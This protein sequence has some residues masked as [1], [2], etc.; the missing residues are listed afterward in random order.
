MG[1]VGKRRRK[2][3][4]DRASRPDFIIAAPASSPLRFA[5]AVSA[6]FTYTARDGPGQ[7]SSSNYRTV[8]FTVLSAIGSRP[9]HLP[10]VS[11]L[12]MGPGRVRAR[13][14]QLRFFPQSQTNCYR[15][16]QC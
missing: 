5:P 12:G 6:P 15:Q 7:R 13:T 16:Q 10:T 11:L 2:R 3:K 14:F 9:P 1:E 4:E 8:L